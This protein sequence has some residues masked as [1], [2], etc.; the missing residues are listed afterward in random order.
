MQVETRVVERR[1]A[2]LRPSDKNART[3]TAAKRERLVANLTH[4]GTLTSAPL[5]YQDRIISGHHRVKAAIA[6]GIEK[7]QV[8]EITNELP[9]DHLTALQLSHNSISGEDDPNV[10][11]EMLAD[12]SPLMQ[13]FAA[14]PPPDFDTIGL[15]P[16]IRVPPQVQATVTFLDHEAD[17]FQAN[18]ER[19]AKS[20][21][22]QQI[23]PAAGQ[24]DWLEA[25][26]AVKNWAEPKSGAFSL[27]A[28][29]SLMGRLAVER[30]EQLETGGGDA[31]E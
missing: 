2:D 13:Q 10:L 27:P 18:A 28:T 29:L 20:K 30:L 1:L 9:D 26:F 7:A 8:I 17:G 25:L 23:E 5:V 19:L 22:L 21:V 3:M 31:A 6:A 15:F 16:S 24:S 4:D 12:L 11:Q 14:V